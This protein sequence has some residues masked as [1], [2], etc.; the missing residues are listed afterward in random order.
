MQEM[1]STL[2]NYAR[3]ALSAIRMK[4]RIIVRDTF[5]VVSLNAKDLCSLL[6]NRLL[7]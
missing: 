5:D 7:I 1:I 2:T 6:I 4:C 3:R